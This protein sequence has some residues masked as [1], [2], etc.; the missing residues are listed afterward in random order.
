M[1]N[2]NR[3][4][5]QSIIGG[6]LVIAPLVILALMLRWAVD[7]IRELIAPLTAPLV[8]VTGAPVLAVDLLVLVLIVCGCFLIGTFVSTRTGNWVQEFIDQRLSKLVGYG[9]IRDIIRQ[10]LGDKSSSPFG[11]GEVALVRLF[12]SDV[13]TQATALITSRHDNGWY[14]VFIPTGPNP[15]S[16]LIYHLPG[17]CVE[18]RPDIKVETAFKTIIACGAGSAELFTNQPKTAP[19]SGAG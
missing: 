8:K 17:D 5:R 10:L 3:F 19:N 9:L 13:E 14:T 18:P 4:V 2:F 12:G 11:S 1:T 15:T 7:V 16:G 6:V